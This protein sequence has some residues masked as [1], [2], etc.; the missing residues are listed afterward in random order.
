M[1]SISETNFNDD[2]SNP[3]IV[4]LKCGEPSSALL[5]NGTL[6]G[7]AVTTAVVTIDTSRFRNPCTKLE[8]TSNIIG[9]GFVGTL[10]FQVFKSCDNERPIPIGAQFTFAV[11]VPSINANTFTFFLCDCNSCLSECCTYTVVVTA[12]SVVINNVGVFA[13]RL[14]AITVGK[15]RDFC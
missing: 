15:S 5:N 2:N 4:A 9:T 7:T 1:N 8:F 3:R 12:G 14:V 6:G 11:T 10:N 13:A